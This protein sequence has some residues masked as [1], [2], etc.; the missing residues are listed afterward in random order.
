MNAKGANREGADGTSKPVARRPTIDKGAS[1]G[2]RASEAGEGT[3]A[4]GKIQMKR[5]SE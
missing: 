1:A 5:E 4:G 2:K 3:L